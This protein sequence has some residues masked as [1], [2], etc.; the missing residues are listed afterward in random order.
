[1]KTA[2]Y[3][4]PCLV[5]VSLLADSSSDAA[6]VRSTYSFHGQRA[7]SRVDQVAV[8]LEVGGETK[9]L[10]KGKLQQEKLGI[11]CNLEYIEKTLNVPINDNGKLRAIRKYHKATAAVKV[12]KDHFEPT[13]EPEHRTIVVE[14]SEQ[15]A[16]LFSPGGSLSR[17]ELDAIDI[18]F[19]TLLLDRLLPA[20]PVVVGHSWT[21]DKKMLAIMLGLDEVDESTV[22]VKLT[23]VTKI[24]ARF[25][26]NGR[27]EGRVHGAST[28]IELK[29][30]YRFDLRTKRVDWVGMLIKENRKTSEIADGLD[31]VSRLQITVKPAKETSELSDASVAKIG[32]DSAA[33]ATLLAYEFPGG[34]CRCKYDRRWFV[35]NA[36]G[37]LRLMDRGTFAGQCNLAILPNREP[38]RLV[39]LEDFQDDVRKALGDNFGEFVAARQSVNGNGIRVLRVEAEGAVLGE[40]DKMPIRWIYYHLAD[41]N[42]RQAAVTFTIE[43]E[44]MDRFA[45]ADETIVGSLEFVDR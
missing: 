35:E 13:L 20:G 16:L 31:V 39:S 2:L 7:P 40:T 37:V 3:I 44:R 6:D 5:I 11:V 33:G 8:L 14:A 22:E 36:S 9:F 21:P 34:D 30:R 12:G 24:V 1:M 25:E 26:L 41:R 29:G 17:N 19:N 42:G 15:E 32:L 38:D 43:Q 28:D 18:H 23:E 4:I 45:D 27:V 10:V